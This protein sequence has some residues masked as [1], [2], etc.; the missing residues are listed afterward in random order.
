[1]S[2]STRAHECVSIKRQVSR[3]VTTRIGQE[4]EYSEQTKVLIG[5][6]LIYL[7]VMRLR[8]VPNGAYKQ[9]SHIFD[10][11]TQRRGRA[12]YEHTQCVHHM[13]AVYLDRLR[14][15]LCQCESIFS[16]SPPYVMGLL[17]LELEDREGEKKRNYRIS[18]R[19]RGKRVEWRT[20]G[21]KRVKVRGINTGSQHW[22]HVVTNAM[23]T[24]E[25][26]SLKCT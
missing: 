19:G 8:S 7:N 21:K 14:P 2:A 17:R 15:P 16:I 12:R 23:A 20:G 22:W 18:D 24:C 25:I 10:A 26:D 6:P 4:P 5:S 1:M 3:A 9:N 13:A 11:R